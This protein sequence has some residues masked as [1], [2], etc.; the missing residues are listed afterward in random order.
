[1]DFYFEQQKEKD[2]IVTY[3]RNCDHIYNAHFHINIELLIIRRGKYKITVDGNSYIVQ[4]GDIALFE[5]YSIHSYDC[6]LSDVSENDD[7]VLVIP[8]KYFIRSDK[9]SNNRQIVSP[10]IHDPNLV[11]FILKTTDDIFAKK[12]AEDVYVSAVNLILS[13]ITER[14]RYTENTKYGETLND[15]TLVHNCL[16]YIK[17]N[18]LDD[19]SRSTLAKVF[20][21]S[22]SYIS[23]V[24]GK[25]VKMSI[26]SYVNNLKVQ[27]IQNEIAAHPEKSIT[28]IILSSGFNNIQAYYYYTNKHCP[29]P[30]TDLDFHV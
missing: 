13:L 16:T 7:C 28:E 9:K 6:M 11:D 17:K 12:H 14:M 15:K 23:H 19:C 24:F 27:H 26:P 2:D 22:E 29:P 20:G 3:G 18:F 10:I 30:L 21:Y 4:D 1:M 25:Y 8:S 5:S